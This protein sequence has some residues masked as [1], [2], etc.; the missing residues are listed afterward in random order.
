MGV[1]EKD[2]REIRTTEKVKPTV[3]WAF[4]Y[5]GDIADF[6]DSDFGDD[7]YLIFSVRKSAEKFL[8]KSKLG[9]SGWK[10]QKV[11]II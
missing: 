8:K 7:M 3:A 9:K 11:V 2:M 10:V 1:K 6:S 5:D 4:H